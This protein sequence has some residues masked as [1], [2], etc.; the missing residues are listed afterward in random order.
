MQ[1]VQDEEGG[2]CSKST[3]HFELGVWAAGGVI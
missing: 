3:L 2:D 1:N